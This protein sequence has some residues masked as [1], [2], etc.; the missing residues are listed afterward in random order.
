L[1]KEFE[2]IYRH[3]PDREQSFYVLSMFY[4]LCHRLYTKLQ[5]TVTPAIDERIQA[6]VQ[7]IYAHSAEPLT[8]ETLASLSHMSPSRFYYCF[9][10][11]TGQTP[12]EYKNN[13]CIRRAAALLVTDRYRSVEQ[14]SSEVGFS[15]A[16]YF[17][18]VFKQ[19]YD[20]TPRE[21]RQAMLQNI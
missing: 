20:Y 15:S 3:L 4:N 1:E 11:E 10:K 5:Y 8:V 21:Y 16:A 18:R 9:K 19:T 14:I 2:Y 6:A 12:I 7:Y 17:R 13:V